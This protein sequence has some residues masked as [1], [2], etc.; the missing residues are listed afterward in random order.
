MPSSDGS[1]S[2]L[3]RS[4]A[5]LC[6]RERQQ[7]ENKKTPLPCVLTTNGCPPEILGRSF[8]P[9]PVVQRVND[10]YVKHERLL[11]EG[12]LSRS[13]PSVSFFLYT[14]GCVRPRPPFT[15]CVL[16]L[17]QHQ[18]KVRDAVIHSGIPDHVK[19]QHA[20]TGFEAFE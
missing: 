17:L 13:L 18:L 12:S 20:V 9:R 15:H 1:L 19:R 8:V 4:P 14:S 7:S 16:L 5:Y 10:Q 6:S 11:P 3:I 2:Y